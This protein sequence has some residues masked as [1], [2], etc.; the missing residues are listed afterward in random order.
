MNVDHKNEIA[1][2]LLPFCEAASIS[3][4]DAGAAVKK[5][6]VV[7]LV[8][9][10]D[11]QNVHKQLFGN[12]AHLE[13]QHV[14]TYLDGVSLC[15]SD[16]L[17]ILSLLD[18]VEEPAARDV[19][20]DI[21]KQ[22]GLTSAGSNHN[23]SG[24]T[25]NNGSGL[26]CTGVRFTPLES[27]RISMAKAHAPVTW[28]SIC[29]ALLICNISELDAAAALSGLFALD[30][31]SR[32]VTEVLSHLS[33]FRHTSDEYEKDIGYIL[34]ESRCRVR[35]H[36][37]LQSVER[38][39]ARTA[40]LRLSARAV[41]SA[42]KRPSLTKI[43]QGARRLEGEM[44]VNCDN[45]NTFCKNARL[46]ANSN[47]RIK[48]IAYFLA[49]LPDAVG[50]KKGVMARV[51]GCNSGLGN[52]VASVAVLT[53][54]VTAVRD[55]VMGTKHA[56]VPCEDLRRFRDSC[57]STSMINGGTLLWT[58]VMQLYMVS[59]CRPTVMKELLGQITTHYATCANGDALSW[60]H[61]TG[62]AEVEGRLHTFARQWPMA[63]STVVELMLQS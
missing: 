51:L 48:L 58:A 26:K 45:L 23:G 53:P 63:L 8:S 37:V 56:G 18:F 17:Q 42:H 22:S 38:V 16:W 14:R 4:K 21:I 11:N 30:A 15:A 5:R 20:I 49:C 27:M 47:H 12:Q 29:K 36:L 2:V 43:L 62:M 31:P 7:S 6:I 28:D 61:A 57:V 32:L 40:G 25:T 50:D 33:T 59:Y 19:V 46:S 60:L 34:D 13:W 35:S 3:H 9:F 55:A 10:I 41:F 39:E 44:G 24:V 54:D 1:D 52:A